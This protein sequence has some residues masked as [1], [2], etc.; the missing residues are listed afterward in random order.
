M[1][2]LSAIA[3]GAQAWREKR[4]TA[5]A[6]ASPVLHRTRLSPLIFGMHLYVC[7]YVL[8]SSFGWPLVRARAVRVRRRAG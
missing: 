8:Y 1:L 4:A 7:M 2:F 5:P 6:N 3:R